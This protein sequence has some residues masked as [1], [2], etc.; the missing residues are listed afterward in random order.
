MTPPDGQPP[1]AGAALRRASWLG[2]AVFSVTAGAATF[3]LG[4]DPDGSVSGV[5]EN[6]AFAVAVLLF[7][8]GC[9][10]F[11]AAYVGGI[12]RSRT[13]E[14][15]VTTL[16]FLAGGV[17]TEVRRSLLGSLGVQV[18]VALGTAIAQPYTSLAAGALVPMYGL[19]LC[20]L[21][22][23]RHGTFPSREPGPRPS[24]EPGPRPPGQPGPARPKRTSPR[25][26]RSDD[27]PGSVDGS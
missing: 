14:V 18:V 8:A 17:A 13:D 24:R 20:G 27:E 21:W 7:L 26:D 2:T 1:P 19:G 10:V 15:A 6:V 25:N 3:V 12:A 5:L 22:S 9:V 23:A 4:L 11:L 16:F